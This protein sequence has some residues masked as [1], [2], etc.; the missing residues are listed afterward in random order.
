MGDLWYRMVSAGEC[1]GLDLCQESDE[2]G[3]GVSWREAFGAGLR[4][5]LKEAAADTTDVPFWEVTPDGFSVYP[6]DAA[7]WL[8]S[9]EEE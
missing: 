9:L 7:R 6:S 8:L 3:Y 4:A 2:S 1:A 5:A